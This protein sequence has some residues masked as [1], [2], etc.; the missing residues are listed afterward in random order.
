MRERAQ[1]AQ[2]LWRELNRVGLEAATHGLD[3]D[4]LG[5]IAIEFGIGLPALDCSQEELEGY[6]TALHRELATQQLAIVHAAWQAPRRAIHAQ[7]W[8]WSWT[9]ALSQLTPAHARFGERQLAAIA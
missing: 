3:T 8:T 2:R 7:G 5:Y 4:E 6:A 1:A 9:N